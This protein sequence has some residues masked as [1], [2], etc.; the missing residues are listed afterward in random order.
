M[1]PV[2][3]TMQRFWHSKQCPGC[4]VTLG[5]FSNYLGNIQI[6]FKPKYH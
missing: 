1:L 6:G 4:K 3:W 5:G 2:Q